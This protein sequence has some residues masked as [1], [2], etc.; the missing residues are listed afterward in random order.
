MSA[1]TA[2]IPTKL[3]IS[4]TLTITIIDIIASTAIQ[5]LLWLH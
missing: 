5:W 4:I 2:T 1:I 3:T